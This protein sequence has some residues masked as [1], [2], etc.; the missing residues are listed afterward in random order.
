MDT[1]AIGSTTGVAASLQSGPRLLAD[2]A[3]KA[4]Q[5]SHE[6]KHAEETKVVAHAE[7]P[8][9]RDARSL[10]YQ[11][12]VRT[13]RVVAIVVDKESG[14]VVREIPDPEVLRI[15]QAIDRMK[16]FLVEEKV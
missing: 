13:H 7:P 14:A 4:D 15:A 12:D 8:P 16:G 5:A 1:Q 10:Q 9:Q 11:V 2:S 6:V 3:A